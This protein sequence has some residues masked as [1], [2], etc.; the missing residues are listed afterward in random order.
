MATSEWVGAAEAGGATSSGAMSRARVPRG[1][2]ASAVSGE[3]A[4]GDSGS[5]TM[6][7]TPLFTRLL[8]LPIALPQEI[9]RRPPAGV[10]RIRTSPCAA[11]SSSN[12]AA[13]CQIGVGSPP[14]PPRRAATMLRISRDD[15]QPVLS[16]HH[17]TDS[18]RSAVQ[19]ART[20]PH[21][22][23]V[24][25][26]YIQFNSAFG[27]GLA[28]LAGEI[29]ARQGL[30]RDPEEA[31]HILADRAAEVAADFFYAAV[32]EFDDRATPWRDTH[33]TLAQATLKGMAA[34]FGYE[35]AQLNDLLEV[36]AATEDAM[37]QVWEGYGVGA[38][39]EEARLFQAM[40]FHTGSEI[41]ADQEFVVL[42]QAL[43][44][45]RPEMVAALEGM[46]VP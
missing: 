36:N 41:L 16:T 3:A 24:M 7:R 30:F 18:L 25:A 5:T 9:R 45:H 34:F 44:A 11:D 37:D 28:N 40:G 38:H 27:P 19:G 39:L 15:L 32:D 29:A 8:S 14:A 31:V 43:R 42:D 46:K 26:R 23:S 2:G 1:P 4:P 13:R 10:P 22:L 17:G 6:S 33:R 12:R 35:P 21:F 20:P